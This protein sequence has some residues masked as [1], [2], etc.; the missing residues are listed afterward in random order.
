MKSLEIVKK[1]V[2]SK[3]FQRFIF[4]SIVFVFFVHF[5]IFQSTTSRLFNYKNDTSYFWS[6]SAIHYK[7]AK[8]IANN[9][10]L[11]DFDKKLQY[12]E[13][14]YIKKYLPTL[15]EY[16]TGKT[17]RFIKALGI[18]IPFHLFVIYFMS[19]I[20]SLVIFPLFAISLNLWK[21]QWIGFLI[22]LLY[23]ILP[24]G[25]MR[26]VESFFGEIF[27]Y[28]FILTSL[29]LFVLSLNSKNK[30]KKL[31]ALL[32]GICLSIAILSWNLSQFIFTL[33][34]GF[35]IF[36]YFFTNNE[37]EKSNLISSFSILFLFIILT[38]LITKVKTT[39]FYIFSFPSI[40]AASIILM[41]EI[42]K[43]KKISKK[44]QIILTLGIGSIASF[45]FYIFTK[46]NIAALN[47]VF[48]LIYGKILSFFGLV[49][50]NSL[51][52]IAKFH[53][54]SAFLSPSI[55]LIFQHFSFTILLILPVI[56]LMLYMFF[57]KKLNLTKSIS[58][59]FLV[60]F[61]VLYF[62][63]LRFSIFL[64]FFLVLFLGKYYDYFQKKKY[65][66][67][68]G[69]G[70]LMCV[71]IL[72]FQYR[73]VHYY[74]IR[75]YWDGDIVYWI[76]RNTPKNSVFLTT[77]NLSA[78]IYAYDDR[79]VVIHPKSEAKNVLKKVEKFYESVYGDEKN[80][81]NLCQKWK[82]DYFIYL[83]PF[84]L[85]KG[86]SS[87]RFFVNRTNI[88]K[89]SFV[90]KC[91]FRP[92]ELKHFR[93]I[94]QNPAYRIF[95]VLKGKISIDKIGRI[96]YEPIYDLNVFNQNS[97]AVYFDD[98]KVKDV[99]K[100]I[101][102]VGYRNDLADA[103]YSKKRYKD[104]LYQ[105]LYVNVK[106]PQ[107][108]YTLISI[109]NCYYKLKEYKNALKYYLFAL[110]RK[111]DVLPEFFDI[112]DANFINETGKIMGRSNYVISAKKWYE[113][114][115]TKEPTNVFSLNGLA[116]AYFYL[117]NPE[118]AINIFKKALKINPS[119]P[120]T[121][122]N[123]GIIYKEIGDIKNAVKFLKKYCK[124]KPSSPDVKEIKDFINSVERKK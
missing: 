110:K 11:P 47:F 76:G 122:K 77:V 74:T 37:N 94:H 40:F 50:I 108:L 25:S 117:K 124:L 121:Y 45:V 99:L 61:F 97:S 62:M 70:L 118:K 106:K 98:S 42:N 56:A 119:L 112:D 27:A 9:G 109:G 83:S 55:K 85:E 58:F 87:P 75:T 43:K 35:V 28:P 44:L 90:F 88:S 31:Y 24:P 116:S 66:N 80:F 19:F 52:F 114:A 7:F 3:I 38:S 103:L 8:I 120:L 60:V 16:T 59:Y 34:V 78:A 30:R 86:K 111:P 17:Y 72:F 102:D 21:N 1:V 4:L 67:F 63:F 92:E 95:R 14:L 18:N 101:A 73:K 123:L 39:K 115:L 10:K 49:N 54:Q 68:V 100:K 57:K 82:V 107:E 20:S 23:V 13:G 113:Y 89:D 6:E 33:I 65:K 48:E 53:W 69:I 12:P 5:K 51:P 105:Y 104:A 36:Y 2:F 41:H 22:V 96:Y 81:Y 32:S 93:L 91:H 46:K 29:T 15:M 71:I 26:T 79:A 64:I 84:I